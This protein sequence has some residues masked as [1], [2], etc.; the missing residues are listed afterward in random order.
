VVLPAFA[1]VWLVSAPVSL[2]RRVIGLVASAVT[3]ATASFWWVA[4]VELIPSTSRPYIGGSTT[5]SPLDL[6]LGYDGLGRIFGERPGGVALSP[7][8]LGVGQAAGPGGPS[9]GG[10]PGILRLFNAEFGGQIGWL[11]PAALIALA[12]GLVLY[13]RAPRADRRLSGYLLW[14]TWLACHVAV[15]SL[16]SGIIHPYYSVALAPA[17]AALVGAGALELWTRRRSTLWARVVLAVTLIATGAVAWIV[18]DRTPGFAPGLGI[19]I[20]AMSAAASLLVAIPAALVTRRIASIAIV[21]SLGVL[22]AGPLAYAGA[23]MTTAYGGGDP[24]AGP[25]AATSFGRPGSFRGG[26]RGPAARGAGGARGPGDA[27]ADTAV[28]DYLVANRG[29]AR[30]IVAANGSDVAAG[31]QLAANLPV[32]TMGGFNGSD[33]APTLDQLKSAIAKGELRFVLVDS[34]TGGGPFGGFGA[35]GFG[36]GARSGFVGS[37]PGGSGRS[38][39][40]E[41]T[42][43]VTST[44]TLVEIPGAASGLYDCG[45][46]AEAS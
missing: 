26:D 11:L 24:A 20:L 31:I 23:T 41:R 14:G 19:G 40:S 21:M 27:A 15:F 2:R 30:W 4:V 42:A 6:L 9:F 29:T 34:G 8:G 45:S 36:G 7:A 17:I 18:L 13:R 33:P 37:G 12:A 10:T 38:I 16:M 44:C 39:T 43:W 22:L 35:G 46:A 32:M 1:V 3:V 5:N 25:A 28:V